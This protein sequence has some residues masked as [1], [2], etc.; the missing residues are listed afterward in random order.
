MGSLVLVIHLRLDSVWPWKRLIILVYNFHC[1][2]TIGRRLDNVLKQNLRWAHLDSLCDFR[3][4]LTWTLVHNVELSEIFF[5]S[6]RC[7]RHENNIFCLEKKQQ[8]QQEM[9]SFLDLLILGN[10]LLSVLRSSILNPVD[11]VLTNALNH[12]LNP[13]ATPVSNPGL[14]PLSTSY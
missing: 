2:S 8:F 10:S 1:V 9:L 14:L 5:P 12:L 7:S 3:A 11:K 6:S 4:A 13:S